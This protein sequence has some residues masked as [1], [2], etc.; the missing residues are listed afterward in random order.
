MVQRFWSIIENISPDELGMI[1]KVKPHIF[2]SLAT[3]I[4]FKF[5]HKRYSQ[6]IVWYE[7]FQILLKQVVTQKH[8]S[9]RFNFL[10]WNG[11]D[12]E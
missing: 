6:L 9:K 3:I 10:T 11:N 8:M 2:F 12:L 1:C 7:R 4:Y 5:T